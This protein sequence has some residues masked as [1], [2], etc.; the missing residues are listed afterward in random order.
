MSKAYMQLVPLMLLFKRACLVFLMID[1]WKNTYLLISVL[2]ILLDT[3]LSLTDPSQ[4][5][6]LFQDSFISLY[7]CK[8]SNSMDKIHQL[9]VTCDLGDHK[10]KQIKEVIH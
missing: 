6:S 5:W 9:I 1:Q 10:S 7:N 2:M 4:S 8:A 3:V